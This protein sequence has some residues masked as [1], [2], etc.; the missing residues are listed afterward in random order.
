VRGV[1][2]RYDFLPGTR[3]SVGR[4]LSLNFALANCCSSNVMPQLQCLATAL[5]YAAIPD[6]DSLASTTTFGSNASTMGSI[7]QH[8]DLRSFFPV[9]VNFFAFNFK[10]K[11]W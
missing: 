5:W 11:L 7:G 1:F 10:H 3:L 6:L 2:Y 9:G 8:P 4:I